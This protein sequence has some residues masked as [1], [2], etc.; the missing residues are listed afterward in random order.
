MI[1]SKDTV[2]HA[3]W[4]PDLFEDTPDFNLDSIIRASLDKEFTVTIAKPTHVSPVHK[5]QKFKPTDLHYIVPSVYRENINL[6]RTARSIHAQNLYIQSKIISDPTWKPSGLELSPVPLF[7]PTHSLSSSNFSKTCPKFDERSV[8]INA[9]KSVSLSLLNVG[10]TH[11]KS[12]ALDKMVDSLNAFLHKF[13]N[14]LKSNSQHNN[15]S[16]LLPEFIDPLEQTLVE[17]GSDGYEG[18]F[19]FWKE[20][21]VEY[22]QKLVMAGD[23]LS[24]MQEGL[25]HKST[26]S[27]EQ[28]DSS[29]GLVEM[30]SSMI[31]VA[32]HG[33][34]L[35][36]SQ[37]SN[38]SI[39]SNDKP[40]RLKKIKLNS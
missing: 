37:D 35:E 14:V 39:Y 22:Q 18:L 20:H 11:S 17:T 1:N 4:A 19:E 2:S 32:A 10:F 12:S 5:T 27:L 38:E 29:S 15:D 25:L 24:Q 30:S 31:E 40:N 6:L 36:D 7:S 28:L 3:P 16:H 33:S 23:K 13:C 34:V 8:Y 21:M 26:E 9:R